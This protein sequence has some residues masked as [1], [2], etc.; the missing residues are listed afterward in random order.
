M[1]QVDKSVFGRL[2]RLFSRDVIITAIGNNRLRIVDINKLQAQGKLESN[3]LYSRFN[4]IYQSG[5]FATTNTL[6]SGMVLKNA[7]YQ[8][9]D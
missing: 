8:D 3:Y 6:N 9:Y 7:L 4:G 5:Q 2:K 1:S